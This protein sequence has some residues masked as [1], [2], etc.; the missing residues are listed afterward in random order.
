MKIVII[1]I[2][3]QPRGWEASVPQDSELWE[4]L[5]K[6]LGDKETIGSVGQFSAEMRAKAVIDYF[7]TKG[8]SV[9]K[10]CC[11]YSNDSNA[12]FATTLLLTSP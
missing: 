10:M 8:F 6:L 12:L 4:D 1:T 2:C 3:T 11:V 9:D 5:F 7:H